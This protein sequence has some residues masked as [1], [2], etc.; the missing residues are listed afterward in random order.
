[1]L[2]QFAKLKDRKCGYFY[3]LH[4]LRDFFKWQASCVKTCFMLTVVMTLL[5]TCK[6]CESI[7]E[8]T[9]FHSF[10][11]KKK[12]VRRSCVRRFLS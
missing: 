9:F 2:T 6:T 5:H 8:L 11:F 7:I 3:H 10:A 4:S 12:S 1:M